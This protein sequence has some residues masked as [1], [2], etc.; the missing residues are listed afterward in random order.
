LIK[1]CGVLTVVL[2]THNKLVIV[3]NSFNKLLFFLLSSFLHTNEYGVKFR[4]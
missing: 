3:T 4:L 2:A 1:T